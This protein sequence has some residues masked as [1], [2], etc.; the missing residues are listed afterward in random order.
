MD[1]LEAII[2][3]KKII[4]PNFIKKIIPLINKKAKKK[5]SY[6]KTF[7]YKHKKRKRL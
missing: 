6:W 2:E 5:I 4:Q 1:H 7:K 3:L